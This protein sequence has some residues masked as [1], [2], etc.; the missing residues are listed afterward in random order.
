MLARLDALEL[1]RWAIAGIS[2]ARRREMN[3]VL[4]IGNGGRKDG[5][6]VCGARNAQCT[7]STVN[8]HGLNDCCRCLLSCNNTCVPFD[9]FGHGNMLIVPFPVYFKPKNSR[10]QIPNPS[11]SRFQI[12]TPPPK[13]RGAAS[14]V[15]RGNTTFQIPTCR[16][17][18]QAAR[19][20]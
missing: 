19:I 9:S 17:T 12:P 16:Q 6:S 8:T 5:V 15:Q 2:G 4:V 20:T 1:V 10:F 3:K 13:K 11:K 14:H 7:G 18:T